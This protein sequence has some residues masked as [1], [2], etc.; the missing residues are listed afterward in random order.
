MIEMLQQALL[1]A[2]VIVGCAVFL[3]AVL[4]I[5]I[6][7]FVRVAEYLTRGIIK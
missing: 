3:G 1:L 6:A 7:T 2:I 4:A 5:A